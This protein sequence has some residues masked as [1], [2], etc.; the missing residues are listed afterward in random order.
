MSFFNCWN[1]H[2]HI[3]YSFTSSDTFIFIRVSFHPFIVLICSTNHLF[4]IFGVLRPERKEV[5]R[6]LNLLY[7]KNYKGKNIWMINHMLI[8]WFDT[9]PWISL[10]KS[11]GRRYSYPPQ[12]SPQKERRSNGGADPSN[13]CRSVRVPPQR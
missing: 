3:I 6:W 2:K 12:Y 8:S 4:I 1:I 10:W 7:L 11:S 9:P 13:S 5:T